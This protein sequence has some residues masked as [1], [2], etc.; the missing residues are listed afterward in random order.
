[1][2]S[3]SPGDS[4]CIMHWQRKGPN[5]TTASGMSLPGHH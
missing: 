1:L 2:D 4:W 5:N 3:A